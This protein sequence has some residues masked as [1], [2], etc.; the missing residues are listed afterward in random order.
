LSA[1]DARLA[2]GR[3]Y[4]VLILIKITVRRVPLFDH[5]WAKRTEWL[6]HRAGQTL[7]ALQSSLGDRQFVSR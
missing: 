1:S 7:Q 6:I 4:E 5:D 2:R 3:L